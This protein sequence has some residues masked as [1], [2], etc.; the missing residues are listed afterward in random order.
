MAEKAIILRP[1]TPQD[2]QAVIDLWQAAGLLRAWNNPV[3]DIQRKLDELKTGGS[4]WFWVAE[5]EHHIV[6][7]VMAGYDGHRGSVNYLA[8]DP[9]H[10]KKGIG[11]ML[12]ERIEADLSAKGCPKINLLVREGNED[13]LNFYDQ[14]GY[15]KDPTIPLSKRLISDE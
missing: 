10:R 5:L 7:A 13:V 8:V 4:G 6:G 12:M 14:I 3:T 9:S 1:F 2:A 11:R 15:Q